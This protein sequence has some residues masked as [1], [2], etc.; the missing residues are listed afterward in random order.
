MTKKF[1]VLWTYAANY[2]SLMTVA[3]KDAEE[4]RALTVGLYGPDFH[5]AACVYVFDTAPALYHNCG[6]RIDYNEPS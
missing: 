2:S 4:A 1:Y 3:A 5:K 6:E